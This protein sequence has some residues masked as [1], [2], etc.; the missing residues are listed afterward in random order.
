VIAGPNSELDHIISEHLSISVAK[1]ELSVVTSPNSQLDDMTSDQLL[2][3][4]AF[5]FCQM[6]A[7][8]QKHYNTALDGL[9][10]R[11]KEHIGRTIRRAK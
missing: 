5:Q 4:S 2:I 1:M 9:E 8:V 10:I 7:S 11:R 3:S 6:T